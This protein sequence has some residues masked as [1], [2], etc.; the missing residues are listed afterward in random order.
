MHRFV[1]LIAPLAVLALTACMAPAGRIPQPS[2]SDRVPAAAPGISS[3]A[4]S[5]PA[6]V[7]PQIV[8]QAPVTQ[9][10]QAHTVPQATVQPTPQQQALLATLKNWGAAPELNNTTW[11]NSQPLKLAE[12]HGKVVMVEFWTLGCINCRNVLPALRDWHAKYAAQGLEIIGVHT[13]EFDYEKKLD[14]IQAAIGRLDVSWPVAVDN[15]W[16]TWRA[17]QNHYWPAM[18]LIDK[19][20]NIRYLKIGEGQYDHTEAII[21]ALL[22][23]PL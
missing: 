16:A 18:Y 6:G 10:A 1:S 9:Q 4:P 8:V 13:P 11:F 12:L 15:D 20:G 21:Q 19:A 2:V 3:T 7:H 17:Y 5:L 23:E 14:N 22:A